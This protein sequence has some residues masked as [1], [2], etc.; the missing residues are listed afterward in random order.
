MKLVL[1]K[2]LAASV[3]SVPSVLRVRRRFETSAYRRE[4]CPSLLGLPSVPRSDR[5]IAVLEFLQ[6][7]C[8]VAIFAGDFRADDKPVFI[9]NRPRPRG[10]AGRGRGQEQARYKHCR[11]A[12]LF[13]SETHIACEA[14]QRVEFDRGLF[15][16]Q[17]RGRF[18][19]CGFAA[20]PIG[21][22]GGRA[23]F[24]RNRQ[25]GIRRQRLIIHEH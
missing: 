5:S 3:R 13:L 21:P 1:V 4:A 14:K 18:R 24:L 20:R 8:G 22:R 25:P 10:I 7:Q 6:Q 2:R 19:I 11:F 16:A 9:G 17:P 23:G 15:S 12:A